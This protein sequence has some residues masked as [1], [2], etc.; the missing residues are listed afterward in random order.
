V[1]TLVRAAAIARVPVTIIGTGPEQDHLLNLA[2]SLSVCLKTS[3]VFRII[4]N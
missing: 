1:E 4:C 2:E 3:G